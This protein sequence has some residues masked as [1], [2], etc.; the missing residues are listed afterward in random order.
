M[1]DIDVAYRAWMA[2]RESPAPA[3]TDEAFRVGWK[4]GFANA[5]D[6]EPKHPGTY[7]PKDLR[8]PDLI[9]WIVG[10]YGMHM[11]EGLGAKLLELSGEWQDTIELGHHDGRGPAPLVLRFGSA[12]AR[13]AFWYRLAQEGGDLALRVKL[14]HGH[15]DVAT[16]RDASPG[17]LMRIRRACGPD[18]EVFGDGLPAP[19]A[20]KVPPA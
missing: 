7:Y 18:A 19:T 14:S 5:P 16:V 2:Q 12:E 10:Y 20:E 6:P 17:D 15:A 8:G 3:T 9:G 11:P 1:T 13:S 4:G